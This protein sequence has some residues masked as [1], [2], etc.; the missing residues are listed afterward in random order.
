MV[1][2]RNCQVLQPDW[3]RKRKGGEGEKDET[4][5]SADDSR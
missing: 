2:P 5:F 1:F 4:D 3:I